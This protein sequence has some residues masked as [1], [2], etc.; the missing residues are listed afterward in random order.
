MKKIITAFL[1]LI[2]FLGLGITS[3][4]ASTIPDAELKILKEAFSLIFEVK[5]T[6]WL[7]HLFPHANIFSPRTYRTQSFSS[8]RN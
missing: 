7:I 6:L 1:F 8:I 3:A 2:M 5:N 4:L